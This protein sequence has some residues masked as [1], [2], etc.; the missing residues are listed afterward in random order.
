MA[1]DDAE[2]PALD[3]VRV[4]FQVGN[5]FGSAISIQCENSEPLTFRQGTHSKYMMERVKLL[6]GDGLL[7]DHE[8]YATT[9]DAPVLS[10]GFYTYRRCLQ[11]VPMGISP[12]AQ[13]AAS[14][15]L[16]TITDRDAARLKKAKTELRQHWRELWSSPVSHERKVM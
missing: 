15:P 10:P 11:S 12:S 4:A 5:G 14:C 7:I 1:Q 13:Q 16:N 8:G 2:S 9:T 6:W 3:R